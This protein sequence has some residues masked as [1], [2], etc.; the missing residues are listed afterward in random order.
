MRV[1]VL[2]VMFEKIGENP[3]DVVVLLYM[4]YLIFATFEVTCVTFDLTPC[5]GCGATVA[6]KK[7]N[8]LTCE[9]HFG[10]QGPVCLGFSF[11]TL[12]KDPKNLISR[13][14]FPLAFGL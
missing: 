9:Y 5:G 11:F 8:M 10:D 14:F 2:S 4:R 3:S 12:A 13:C 6:V 1:C 7:R